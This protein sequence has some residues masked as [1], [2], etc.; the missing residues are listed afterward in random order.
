[1]NQGLEKIKLRNYNNIL[2]YNNN[3]NKCLCCNLDILHIIG[4]LA[5][6]KIK[7][8]CNR[9]CAATYNNLK[10]KRP[11]KIKEKKYVLE[12]CTKGEL[13]QRRKNYTYCRIAICK[14]A[15]NKLNKSNLLKVCSN[16]GY[17]KHVEACHVKSVSSFNNDVKISEINSINNLI[18]LCPNCHWE[19]DNNILKL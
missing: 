6:T 19:F 12:D 9:S 10:R 15:R 14:H 17:D 4:K 7:K 16:C 5:E 1:M 18:Y 2:E 11:V 8:F 13:L 3:P